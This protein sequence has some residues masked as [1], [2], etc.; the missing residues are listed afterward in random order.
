MKTILFFILL[1]L[2]ASCSSTRLE[3]KIDDVK[4]DSLADESYMRW[5]EK[6]LS[7]L[8]RDHKIAGCYKGETRD[9]LDSFKKNIFSDSQKSDYWLHVANC[10][11]IKEEWSKAE[12]YYNLLL[13]ETKTKGMKAVAL[14]NLG[15]LHFKFEQWEKGQELLKQS[16]D[17]VPDYKIPK[18]NLAQLYLQFSQYHK[19][20]ELLT[21]PV[22]GRDK[23]VDILFSLANAHLF[24]GELSKAGNYFSQIPKESFT[25]E[26][27]AATYA[28]YLIKQG[29][30]SA[31]NEIIKKRDR[32]DVPEL[33]FISQK[34]EKFLKLK[35]KQ[36]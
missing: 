1:S 35:M 8:P 6:R 29:Q 15:L 28:L 21:S 34:I 14:N 22:F 19:A 24:L 33:T 32:S 9:V 25:R 26:D 17:L 23:D 18:Y 12:F 30:L 27:V 13:Q 20:I 16:I 5:G 7:L 11:F 31:A 36:E 2:L 3:R 10:Y 4:W